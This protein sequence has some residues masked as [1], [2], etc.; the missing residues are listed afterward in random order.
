MASV[1]AFSTVWADVEALEPKDQRRILEDLMKLLLGKPVK[2][3]KAKAVSTSSDGE[4]TGS[5]WTDA[6][7]RASIVFKPL[8]E[9]V[10]EVRVEA[11]MKKIP[12]TATASILKT[13]KDTGKLSKEVFPSEDEL[14]GAFHAWVSISPEESASATSGGSKVSK[15]TKF[16]ELSPEEQKARRSE[17]AKKAAA[18]RAANKAAKAVG[19]AESD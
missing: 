8:R 11:G 3:V 19:G 4:S 7:K 17:S 13:L 1:S 12:G 18:T 10:N 5:W 16:S 2:T 6:T 15:G 9:E 14:K